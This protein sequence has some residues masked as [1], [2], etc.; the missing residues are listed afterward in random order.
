[1]QTL[2][3]QRGWGFGEGQAAADVAAFHAD[4]AVAGAALLRDI[5]ALL[6]PMQREKFYR[7]LSPPPPPTAFW[8][9]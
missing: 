5:R 9:R 8:P 7:L 1:M 4:R 2:H 6:T 3:V